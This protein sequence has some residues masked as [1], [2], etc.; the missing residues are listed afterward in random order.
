MDQQKYLEM[1]Q[2]EKAR[3]AAQ[4]QAAAVNHQRYISS[5]HHS[6]PGQQDA[7]HKDKP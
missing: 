6:F 7:R 5:L 4:Q 1:T 3:Y 2:E